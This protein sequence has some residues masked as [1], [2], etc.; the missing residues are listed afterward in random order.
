MSRVK[1]SAKKKALGKALKRNRRVPLF[2]VA[3]TRRRVAASARRRHW[4]R[5]KLKLKVE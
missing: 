3:K 4:R 1:S 2:V 5:N